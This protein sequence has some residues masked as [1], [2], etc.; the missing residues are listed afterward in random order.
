M[1]AAL[2]VSA[3]WANATRID[4]VLMSINGSPAATSTLPPITA[5]IASK[6]WP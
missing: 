4:S 2:W 1:D 5:A 3:Y 6:S